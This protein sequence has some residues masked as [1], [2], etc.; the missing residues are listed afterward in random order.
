MPVALSVGVLCLTLAALRAAG[1]TA[2]F[3]VSLFLIFLIFLC[4]F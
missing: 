4:L 1:L 3:A 2:A